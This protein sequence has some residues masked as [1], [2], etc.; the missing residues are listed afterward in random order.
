VRCL[1]VVLAVAACGDNLTGTALADFEA[2]NANAACERAVRCGL[3]GDVATCEGVQRVQHDVDLFDAIDA[4]LVRYDGPSAAACIAERAALS[5][6]LTSREVRVTSLAC[7]Q[8]FAGTLKANAA[9]VIDE[10]C[11]SGRC[12]RPGCM[13]ACCTGTCR[14]DRAFAK[15]GKAC[16]LDEDC[17]ADTYCN[18]DGT[19]HALE[20]AAGLCHSDRQCDYGLGCIGASELMAGNCRELPLLG[21]VCPYLA[22]AELGALCRGGSCVAIGLPGDPCMNNFDCSQFAQCDP[23]AQH[24]AA[25]PQIGEACTGLCGGDTYCEPVTHVC[26]MPK[27][28]QS[29]CTADDQCESH[30]CAEGPI[31]D[32]CATRPACL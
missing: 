15:V 6:D 32:F 23:T 29:A 12:D 25:L 31:F 1:V 5:C 11:I 4:G 17:V 22:C 27:S 13:Q 10:E 26:S 28:N 7:E 8:M 2:A 24:C 21:A 20:Q 9:C 30:F 16:T 3:V 14:P 19:C 18:D